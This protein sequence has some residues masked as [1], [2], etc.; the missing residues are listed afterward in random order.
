MLSIGI[1]VH[2]DALA[3]FDLVPLVDAIPRLELLFA[4]LELMRNAVNGIAAAHG[5][6]NAAAAFH[7]FAAETARA[8]LDDQALALDE[9]IAGFHVVEPGQR[10]HRHVIAAR[11]AIQRLAGAHAIDDLALLTPGS[12]GLRLIDARGC[13]HH[14]V[15][16]CAVDLRNLKRLAWSYPHADEIVDLG[17]HHGGRAVLVSDALQGLA[18]ADLVRHVGHSIFR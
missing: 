11:N 14:L 2:D 4:D 1:D 5:I 13:Q 7:A 6:Q 15:G 10:A 9:R 12:V 16:Q 3:G 8:R 17:Q 18:L